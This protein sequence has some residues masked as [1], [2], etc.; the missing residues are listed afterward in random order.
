MESFIKIIIFVLTMFFIPFTVQNAAALT[1]SP[2]PSGNWIINASCTLSSSSS[3]PANLI[4]TS[5]IA[6]TIPSGMIL[7]MDLE[8]SQILGKAGSGLLINAGG[9]LL[10]AATC[11]GRNHCY[12]LETNNIQNWGNQYVTTITNFQD[13]TPSQYFISIEQWD[14]WPNGDFGEVGTTTGVLPEGGYVTNQITFDGWCIGCGVSPIFNNDGTVSVGSQ[15]TYE[16]W[17]PGINGGWNFV[18]SGTTYHTVNNAYTYGIGQQVGTETPDNS[19]SIPQTSLSQI[20]M[21]PSG[22]GGWQYWVAGTFDNSYHPP[23]WISNCSDN[24]YQHVTVGSGTQ[25]SC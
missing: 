21:A 16:V 19:P 8:H 15:H 13:S 12:A 17:D 25:G 5:G 23:V 11:T 10:D 2:P 6:L 7:Q 1:C 4:I 20:K 24:P 22:G 3:V 14:S 9:T 18:D